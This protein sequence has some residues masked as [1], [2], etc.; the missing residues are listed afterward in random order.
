MRIEVEIGRVR[1]WIEDEEY[2]CR[3][4]DG[5]RVHVRDERHGRLCLTHFL[6]I[7]VVEYHHGTVELPDAE[8]A[9]G[10]R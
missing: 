10:D 5:G 7:G 1:A 3:L 2:A 4:C 8:Q 9:G 6:A